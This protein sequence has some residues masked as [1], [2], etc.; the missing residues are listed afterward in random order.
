M[1][2]FWMGRQVVTAL[3]AL[4]ARERERA[5]DVLEAATIGG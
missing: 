4:A 3:D 5:N 1:N 2:S